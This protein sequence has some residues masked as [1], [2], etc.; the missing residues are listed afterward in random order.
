MSHLSIFP[1]TKNLMRKFSTNFDIVL[2]PL[3]F[4]NHIFILIP[5]LGYF[6]IYTKKREKK[7][8]D[9]FN[10]QTILNVDNKKLTML[11]REFHPLINKRILNIKICTFA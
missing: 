5:T 4:P 8:L 3:C 2:Y 7:T 6:T 10:R 9:Y 1:S 11:S